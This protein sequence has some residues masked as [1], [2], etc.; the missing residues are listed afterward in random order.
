VSCRVDW[1]PRL[2]LLLL[3]SQ[4]NSIK[5]VAVAFGL[6]GSIEFLTAGWSDE[7]LENERDML[8]DAM[9]RYTAFHFN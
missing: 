4:P 6:L 5:R 2:L 7:S 3:I 9:N 1:L 8:S